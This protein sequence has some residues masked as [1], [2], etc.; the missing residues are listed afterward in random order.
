M[1]FDGRDSTML[2]SARAAW[3]DAKEAG[4]DVT[5]WKESVSGKFEKQ[6]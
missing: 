4:H 1:L 3:K 2:D 6:N 5:Y